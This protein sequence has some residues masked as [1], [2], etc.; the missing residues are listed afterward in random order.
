[1]K[2]LYT[3][4]VI[5]LMATSLMGSGVALGQTRKATKVQKSAL[6]A[7]APAPATMAPPLVVEAKVSNAKL[8]SYSV[9]SWYMLLIPDN[10]AE[11]KYMGKYPL[12]SILFVTQFNE[13]KL[14]QITVPTLMKGSL[15]YGSEDY[16]IYAFDKIEGFQD[17]ADKIKNLDE[18]AMAS[19]KDEVISKLK[20]CYRKHLEDYNKYLRGI[21]GYYVFENGKYTYAA[22]SQIT[23]LPEYPNGYLNRRNSMQGVVNPWST[24]RRNDYDFDKKA[25]TLDLL[26]PIA[27]SGMEESGMWESQYE[28]RFYKNH[29]NNL[30]KRITVPMSM[31]D[32]KKLFG[33]EQ[34]VLCKS[35]LAVRPKFGFNDRVMNFDI[36][37]IGKACFRK[38]TGFESPVLMFE[39]T[40]TPAKPLY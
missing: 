6:P 16:Y 1:M 19:K 7:P 11:Y 21:N 25:I 23:M 14:D 9:Y 17:T 12:T 5:F 34:E 27:G 13:A 26:G 2:R 38:D 15:R 37:K 36:L 3:L 40:S 4:F 24:V 20:E 28:R 39:I 31:D 35:L 33:A 29:N 8:M 10:I 32:A 22:D 30:P 18:F